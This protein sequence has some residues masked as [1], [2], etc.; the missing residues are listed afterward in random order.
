MGRYLLILLHSDRITG[1]DQPYVIV[2]RFEEES[3]KKSCL[4]VMSKAHKM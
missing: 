2:G 3:I 1:F 4:L